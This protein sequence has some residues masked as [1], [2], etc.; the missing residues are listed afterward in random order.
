MSAYFHY[1]EETGELNQVIDRFAKGFSFTQED[2]IILHRIAEEQDPTDDRPQR[3]ALA[4][5]DLDID[6]QS[7]CDLP[8]TQTFR[9]L[10]ARVSGSTLTP[11]PPPS[12]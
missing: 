8:I 5:L 11:L 4:L 12:P 6:P 3:L 1:L 7:T 10:R 9:R 2:L